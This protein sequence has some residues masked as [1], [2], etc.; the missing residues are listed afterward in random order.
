MRNSAF[1]PAQ[2]RTDETD[3]RDAPLRGRGETL[4]KCLLAPYAP[5]PRGR[6]VV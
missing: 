3:K 6:I 2:C 5:R 4:G 1:Y